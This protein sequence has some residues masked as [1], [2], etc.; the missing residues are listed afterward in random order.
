VGHGRIEQRRN[1]AAMKNTGVALRQFIATETGS[2]ATVFASSEFQAQAG[3]I[4]VAAND[5]VTMALAVM[6]I[7]NVQG[8]AGV[9]LS[10]SERCRSGAAI[11][12]I[13]RRNSK[14][15]SIGLSMFVECDDQAEV[16]RLWENLTANGGQEGT[17]GWLTDPWGLS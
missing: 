4:G 2:H 10:E 12:L 1:N 11:G 16:D 13:S 6:F 8:K 15:N 14:V 9:F 7:L 5:T 3:W 17:C